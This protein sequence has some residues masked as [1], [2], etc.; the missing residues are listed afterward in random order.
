MCIFHDHNGHELTQLE[1]A[2][3]SY[4]VCL[5]HLNSCL[6]EEWSGA[7]R[8]QSLS[9]SIDKRWQHLV[10]EEQIEWSGQAKGNLNQKHWQRVRRTYQETRGKENK[11]QEWLQP[12]IWTREM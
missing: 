6:F 5:I 3:K 8:Q 9:H 12:E 10:S 2:S 4:H 7:S 1:E 11:P